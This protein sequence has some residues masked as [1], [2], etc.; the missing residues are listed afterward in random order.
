MTAGNRGRSPPASI[1]EIPIAVSMWNRTRDVLLH[2]A[3]VD[4]A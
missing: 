1:P 2:A 4:A 3:P